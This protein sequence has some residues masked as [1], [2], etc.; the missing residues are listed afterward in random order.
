MCR[1]ASSRL[2]LIPWHVQHGGG[3]A[4][5]A[6]VFHAKRLLALHEGDLPFAVCF[7]ASASAAHSFWQLGCP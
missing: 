2:S 5:T 3:V 1:R 4:N 6:L 7:S